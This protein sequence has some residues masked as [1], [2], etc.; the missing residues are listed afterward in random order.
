MARGITQD[1]V[2]QA[3]DAILSD[4]EN[5]TVEKLRAALG[6]GSPNTITRM[7][8]SWR[9]QLGTRLRQLSAL[10]DVPDAVGQVMIELWRLAAEQAEHVV[11]G[12]FAK[13]RSELEA[14]H[15]QVDR[16]RAT[17]ETR[18]QSAE[19][20]V[21]QAHI[22]RE[23]AEHACNNLDGQLQDSHA[24]RADLVQQRDRIQ[25]QYDQQSVQIESLRAQ[26]EE[27]QAALQ[28]E[29][30]R[31][32]AHIRAVEDR[33]HQE[34][35]RTRQDAKQWQQRHEAAE[36][37]HRDAAAVMQSQLKSITAQSHDLEQLAARQTGQIAGLE[38]ALSEAYVAA[39]KTKRSLPPKTKAP[40]RPRAPKKSP[41]WPARK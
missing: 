30:N 5:P 27:L 39:T 1:Q 34:I 26:L 13:E 19:I 20:Q 25:G 36:R 10:P 11:D 3:A 41:A 24:L 18:L 15:A 17:W 31:Q 8:D 23:L 37:A 14:A 28:L 16:E 2:D 35:D 9:S 38:K 4:G 29:R 6:T 7:L 21:A 33:S 22:A 32:E 40:A 12:R